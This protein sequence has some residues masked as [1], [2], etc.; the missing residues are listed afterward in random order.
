[1][2]SE[3]INNTGAPCGYL[4][5]KMS[6]VQSFWGILQTV[7]LVFKQKHPAVP[8]EDP[9]RLAVHPHIPCQ[10]QAK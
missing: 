7:E 1:M 10:E 2:G 3:T 9:L 5:E 6:M 8:Y 4:N